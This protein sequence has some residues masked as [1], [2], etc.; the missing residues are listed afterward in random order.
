MKHGRLLVFVAAYEA[1]DTLPGV[2]ARIPPTLFDRFDCEVLVS[3]DASTDGTLEVARDYARRHPEVPL[4]ARRNDA[5]RGY[6]GNQKLGYRHAMRHRFD[7]VALLHGD[8]QYA[9]EC[10]PE[11]LAPLVAGEADAVLGSRMLEPEG[12]LRGGMPLYKFA[13]NRVLTGL[14]N[15]LLGS[16]LSEFHSGYRAY[17]VAALAELP[18][19]LDT[20]GFH[21][22]TEILLQL[23]QAGRRIR[24]VPVPTHYGG[25]VCRV[26]GLRYAR[27]VVRVTAAC[28]LHRLGI[29]YRRRFDLPRGRTAEAAAGGAAQRPE[30]SAGAAEGASAG[31]A[32]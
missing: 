20:D 8:G 6:G 10:L 30:R 24:E 18:L 11:L 23:M 14:Q 1:Q 13:G 21:F 27:D 12:A 5:N 7:W 15:R 17:R 31:T 4:A 22:D 28:A 32:T 25:E 16:R 29:V 19:E 3:D 9:P 2:L 26:D